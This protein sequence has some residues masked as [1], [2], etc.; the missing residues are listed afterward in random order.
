M[1]TISKREAIAIQRQHPGS[2]L[3]RYCTGKYQWHGSVSYYIGQEVQDITGVL[4]VY[5]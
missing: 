4:A 5:P 3:F 1:K 2:R